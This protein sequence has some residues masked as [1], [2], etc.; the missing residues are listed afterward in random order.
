MTLKRIALASAMIAASSTAH[1]QTS[2]RFPADAG[3]VRVTDY[4]ADGSDALDDYAALTASL[5]QA[6]HIGKVWELP[7]GPSG[8]PR[9]YLTSQPLKAQVLRDGVMKWVANWIAVGQ[10]CATLKV[11]DNSPAFSDAAHPVGVLVYGS[12]SGNA[13]STAPSGGGVEAFRNS[14]IGFRISAGVGNPGAYGIDWVCNNRGT[15]RD[16]EIEGPGV[17]GIYM[18][19]PYP[20]PCLVAG[21]WIHGW[22][23]GAVMG[24]VQFGITF[25]DNTLDTLSAVGIDVSSNLAFIQRLHSVLSVPAVRST[26]A[27]AH[28]TIIDSDLGGGATGKAAIELGSATQAFV[29]D[30]QVG[31][32]YQAAIKQGTSFLTS[33]GSL[34]GEW[35]SHPTVPAG[36]TSLRLPYL[37][38][39][40]VYDSRDFAGDWAAPTAGSGDALARVNAAIAT[41]KPILYLPSP[42]DTNW[43]FSDTIEIPC[44]VRRVVF[45]ESKIKSIAWPAGHPLIRLADPS[46]SWSEVTTIEAGWVQ[47]GSLGGGYSIELGD[48][49]TVYIRDMQINVGQ[50]SIWAKQG[51]GRLFLEDVAIRD[52]RIDGPH[53]V[54][55][56]QLNSENITTAIQGN[57]NDG[58]TL[59]VLGMKTEGVA[60]GGN[61]TLTTRGGGATEVLGAN[62]MPCVGMGSS[63]P[64]LGVVVE[65]ADFSGNWTNWCSKTDLDLSTWD[66]QVRSTQDGVTTDTGLA[67]LPQ[68]VVQSGNKVFMPLY[69]VR[70]APICE[71][72]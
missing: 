40:A 70:S 68:L 10:P 42:A 64:Q 63:D 61:P 13:P 23:S 22:S 16:M 14:A 15:I 66:V 4:G 17:A 34:V 60:V 48:A 35:V 2:S 32:A 71:A 56:T 27:S 41:G 51:S 18:G 8:E 3:V 11:V 5:Q 25:D 50:P 58:G 46:C 6:V 59:R 55:A 57:L 1:A 54:W 69:S 24:Q 52:L 49:R 12:T 29:R 53:E 28:V 67:G 39:P 30:V 7:C 44:S 72:P 37:P 62:Y 33:L 36:A 19:R 65:D 45:M 31:A 20:G 47:V 21:N 43:T 26:S 38:P 9:T